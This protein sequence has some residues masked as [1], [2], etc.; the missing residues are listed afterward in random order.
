[1]R[2]VQENGEVALPVPFALDATVE[3][4]HSGTND[5][6][7]RV[8]RNARHNVD[9]VGRRVQLASSH[10]STRAQRLAGGVDVRVHVEAVRVGAVTHVA[11]TCA[12]FGGLNIDNDGADEPAR[13]H[14]Q[15]LDDI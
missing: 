7:G 2:G 8:E 13:L 6:N 9:G 14:V 10:V 4:R 1:C 11:V 5:Q 12:A 15:R 3:I